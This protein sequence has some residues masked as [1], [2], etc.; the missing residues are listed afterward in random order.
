MRAAAW[1]T[2]STTTY[3]VERQRSHSGNQPLADA[4][5]AHVQ[6]HVPLSNNLSVGSAG[7]ASTADATFT[8]GACGGPVSDDFHTPVLN[9]MWTFYA[10]CCGYVKMSGTDAL[11]VVPSVT[12]S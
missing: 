5:L 10:H 9:P 12:S 7:S 11:L 2:V 8:T 4:E 6:Y 1:I 3:G